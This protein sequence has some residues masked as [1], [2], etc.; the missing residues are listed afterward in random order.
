L[1]E[2][3]GSLKPTLVNNQNQSK[4]LNK[5]ISTSI[6]ILIIVICAL[7]VWGVAIWQNKI[8]KEEI[9]IIVK[10][11]KQESKEINEIKTGKIP[12]DPQLLYEIEEGQKGGHQPWRLDPEEV[13]R[14]YMENYGFD[15]EKDFETKKQIYFS[16]EEGITEYE[17]THK[18]KIYIITLIQPS[19]RDKKF[20]FWVISEIRLKTEEDKLAKE[21]VLGYGKALMSR[22]RDNLF[23]YVAGEL[24]K[25]IEKWPPIFGVSN[26]HLEGIE[27]VHLKKL[28]SNEFEAKIR[29]Y[30]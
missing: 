1:K 20:N 18:D 26:P 5:R 15:S 29:L 23:P 14:V 11:K 17:V 27:I 22:I 6:G 19:I 28:N 8:E 16:Q 4:F 10:E 24:K 21:V 2:K 12:I 25:E 3:E 30:Q 9:K 7:L 13:L